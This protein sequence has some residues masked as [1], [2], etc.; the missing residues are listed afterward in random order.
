MSFRAQDTSNC[1]TGAKMNILPYEAGFASGILSHQENHGL[2]VKICILQSGWVKLVEFVV[3]LQW[4]QFGFVKLLESFTDSLEDLW[5]FLS[6]VIGTQ[7]AEHDA[8]RV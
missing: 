7:P 3:F 4:K 8:T 1:F 5:I 6:P 2:I